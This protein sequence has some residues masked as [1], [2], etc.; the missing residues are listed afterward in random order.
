VYCRVLV[1]AVVAYYRLATAA[2][3]MPEP[4]EPRRI[5]DCLLALVKDYW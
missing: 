1:H 5:L 2:E 3:H 4:I